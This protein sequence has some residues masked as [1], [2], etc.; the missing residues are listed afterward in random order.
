VAWEFS[1]D[2]GRVGIDTHYLVHFERELRLRAGQAGKSY[3]VEIANGRVPL[4]ENASGYRHPT[5]IATKIRDPCTG[6]NGG[7]NR[8]MVGRFGYWHDRR[9]EPMAGSASSTFVDVSGLLGF[10]VARDE[11]DPA[12][13]V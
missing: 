2:E 4:F 7:R 1:L 9:R 10:E 8:A 13:I 3:P 12:L 11:Y 6:L 5:G